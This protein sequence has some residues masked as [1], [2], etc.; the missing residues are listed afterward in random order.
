M[1]IKEDEHHT[2]DWKY[3]DQEKRGEKVFVG[4]V[5][6]KKQKEFEKELNLPEITGRKTIGVKDFKT[7]MR[8]TKKLQKIPRAKRTKNPSKDD[9]SNQRKRD[10]SMAKIQD[11]LTKYPD[12]FESFKKGKKKASPPDTGHPITSGGHDDFDTDLNPKREESAQERHEATQMNE[13]RAVKFGKVKPPTPKHLVDP[14]WKSWL[15]K[16]SK[17][18]EVECPHCS[19][20][21]RMAMSMGYGGGM[22]TCRNCGGKGKGTEFHYTDREGNMKKSWQTWLEKAKV[23]KLSIGDKLRLGQDDFDRKEY[24]KKIVDVNMFGMKQKMPEKETAISEEE[25]LEELTD[26]ELEE[27]EKKI[28]ESLKRKLRNLITI[29]DVYPSELKRFKVGE[30]DVDESEDKEEVEKAWETW[31]E[32]TSNQQNRRDPHNRKDVD[33]PEAVDNTHTGV[34]NLPKKHK[35][36]GTHYGMMKP[37]GAKDTDLRR[38]VRLAPHRPT[39]NVGDKGVAHNMTPTQTKFTTDALLHI[40]QKDPERFKR[41]DDNWKQLA[42]IEGERRAENPTPINPKKQPTPATE[43]EQDEEKVGG[44]VE[45]S[46]DEHPD[47]PKWK[48]EVR[49]LGGKPINRKKKS[50]RDLVEK[51]SAGQGDARYGNPHETGMED[52]RKL[53]VTRDDFNM[54]EKDDDNKPFIQRETRTDKDDEEDEQSK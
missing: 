27:V 31:L 13:D 16:A 54:E 38:K 36:T 24:D 6:D 40:M 18:T 29:P 43:K 35:K 14:K 48:K 23:K 22:G 45:E 10:E 1:P 46:K 8:K 2:R 32:K 25:P 5:T 20:K 3:S 39:M 9:G 52:P 53:Q 42:G 30:K 11:F 44:K 12:G 7:G 21:G 26:G 47:E 15:E 19:G 41:M 34:T 49:R 28:P 17:E 50:W 4:N 51:D 37:T 33:D